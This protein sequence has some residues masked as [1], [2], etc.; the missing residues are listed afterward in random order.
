MHCCDSSAKHAKCA[1]KQTTICH[2]DTL[3]INKGYMISQL[4]I[5]QVLLSKLCHVVQDKIAISLAT[6]STSQC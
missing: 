6:K 5:V 3:E 2:S 1:E 4:R